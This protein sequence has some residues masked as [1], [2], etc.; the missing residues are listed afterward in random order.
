M[1]KPTKYFCET[2]IGFSKATK[3]GKKGD[4][5]IFIEREQFPKSNNKMQDRLVKRVNQTSFWFGS[6]KGDSKMRKFSVW[7]FEKD[8][9]I[10][11]AED[12]SKKEMMQNVLKVQPKVAELIIY[13]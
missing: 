1:R 4:I 6:N 13:D 5:I 8:G 11:I 2:A 3:L 10:S 9:F 7:V 12:E